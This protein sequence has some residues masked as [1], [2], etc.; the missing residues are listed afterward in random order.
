MNN[1]E[2][3]RNGISF[4]DISSFSY[5]TRVPNKIPYVGQLL[6]SVTKEQKHRHKFHMPTGSSQ[7]YFRKEY[8]T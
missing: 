1:W 4:H 8:R 3:Y 7:T 5:H 6:A 2:W